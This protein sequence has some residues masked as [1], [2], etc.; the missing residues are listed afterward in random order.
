MEHEKYSFKTKYE[1]FRV[2][3]KSPRYWRSRISEI[4]NNHNIEFPVALCHVLQGTGILIWSIYED[5]HN[6]KILKMIYGYVR[7]QFWRQEMINCVFWIVECWKIFVMIEHLISPCTIQKKQIITLKFLTSI[8]VPG[9]PSHNAPYPR[10]LL[11]KCLM[12]TYFFS[13]QLFINIEK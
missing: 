3:S 7:D 4:I 1:T 9:L 10:S 13:L 12:L 11:Q 5:I 6:L 2:L 8:T